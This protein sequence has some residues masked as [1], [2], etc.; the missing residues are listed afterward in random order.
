MPKKL[1]SGA[2]LAISAIKRCVYDG[3]QMDLAAALAYERQL[4]EPLFDSETPPKDLKLLPRNG[5]PQYRGK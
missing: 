2:T 5:P 4:I 3:I 1:A